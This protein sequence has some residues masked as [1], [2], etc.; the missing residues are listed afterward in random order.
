VIQSLWQHVTSG[1]GAEVGPALSSQD[2]NTLD[3][4]SLVEAYY[5]LLEAARQA[6]IKREPGEPYALLASVPFNMYL[7]TNPDRLIEHALEAAGREPQVAVCEWND[8]MQ[9]H[10]SV[11][12]RNPAYR[13]DQKM[14][15]V[16]Q[17]FG[18]LQDPD[19]LVITEDDYFD[20]L[21]GVTSNKDLIPAGVRRA[22]ADTALMFLG[23]SMDDWSFRVLFRSIMNQGGGSRRNRYAHVAVQINPEEGP[24]I[25]VEAARRF[26][27]TYFHSSAITIYWGSVE[28]FVRELADQWARRAR[29]KA[30]A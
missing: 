7:N 29:A 25:E 13:P 6:R 2:P 24:I 26:F 23:F 11:F 9:P 14:P 20:Y 17:L 18:H 21:I 12:D 8:R 16:Y 19:S 22:L 28:D 15:L 4:A 10:Q 27:E 1:Y 5:E 30:S 3:R